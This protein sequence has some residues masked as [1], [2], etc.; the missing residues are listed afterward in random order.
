M[1]TF[2]TRVRSGP[3][4]AI[5]AVHRAG[6][7]ARGLD[8]VGAPDPTGDAAATPGETARGRS[9]SAR[10]RPMAFAA[11]ARCLCTCLI[12]RIRPAPRKG[13][14]WPV[15]APL[16]RGS[17]EPGDRPRILDNRPALSGQEGRSDALP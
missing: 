5:P 7:P 13:A 2:G 6:D 17:N 10:A 9:R 14:A 16:R 15:L 1:R 8:G 4:P 3:T 12:P 11:S